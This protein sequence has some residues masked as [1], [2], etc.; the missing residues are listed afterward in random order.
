[1]LKVG[2]VG[3]SLTPESSSDTMETEELSNSPTPPSTRSNLTA[4]VISDLGMFLHEKHINPGLYNW[5]LLLVP[6]LILLRNDKTCQPIVLT[7]LGA[8]SWIDSTASLK[9]TQ[10]AGPIVRQVSKSSLVEDVD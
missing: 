1:M 2:L 3:G 8:L 4:E 6:G 10:L 5:S 7:V 9:A